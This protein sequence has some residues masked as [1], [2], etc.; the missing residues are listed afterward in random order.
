VEGHDVAVKLA[1]LDGEVL[2]AQPEYDDVARVASLT[3]RPIKQVLAAAVAAT[4]EL[5]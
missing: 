3:G 2:N 1:L 5:S 4:Q